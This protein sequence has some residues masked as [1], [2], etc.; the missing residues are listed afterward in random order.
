M[1]SPVERM[2]LLKANVAA[3]L[4][5]RTAA[6]WILSCYLL[7]IVGVGV[8]TIRLGHIFWALLIE[9]GG[10]MVASV[11][12]RAM[13]EWAHRRREHRRREQR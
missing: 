10:V 3:N 6:Q 1:L 9:L 11:V 5:S 2:R 12:G 4:R 8:A 7:V 13:I